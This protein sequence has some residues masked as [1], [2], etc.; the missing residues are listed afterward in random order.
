MKVYGKKPN[1]YVASMLT[2]AI[3]ER[4]PFKHC[5]GEREATWLIWLIAR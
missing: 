1:T 3:T 4:K 2:P 5:G